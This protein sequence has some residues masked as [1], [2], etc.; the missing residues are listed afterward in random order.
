LGSWFLQYRWQEVHCE[1][2]Q[3]ECR[4]DS[5]RT[6]RR[7]PGSPGDAAV[8]SRRG[9]PVARSLYV[10]VRHSRNHN[11]PVHS[12]AQGPPRGLCLAIRRGIHRV[13]Q[14]AILEAIQPAKQ[15]RVRLPKRLLKRRAVQRRMRLAIQVATQVATHVQTH[16]PTQ[17]ATQLSIHRRTRRRIR[18]DI[19][20][21]TQD[22][23]E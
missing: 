14:L 13:K 12:S 9:C 1:E 4:T 16:V 22:T 6:G 17:R 21:E 10:V 5:A 3:T 11:S 8:D 20:R 15:R 2:Q 23:Y 19:R 7:E 18:G